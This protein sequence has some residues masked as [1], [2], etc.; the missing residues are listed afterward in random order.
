MRL[1]AVDLPERELARF[2]R[3]NGSWP[4]QEALGAAH[5]EAE[6]IEL[7]PLSDLEGVGLA[8][9]LVEGLGVPEAQIAR[10]R[11]RLEALEGNVMVITSRAFG[12][13]AQELRPRAPLHPIATFTEETPEFHFAPLPSEAARGTAAGPQSAPAAPRQY[14]WPAAALALAILLVVAAIVIAVLA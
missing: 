2:G 9:Y 3:R 4:L 12:G 14:R 6:H 8:G 7:F 10:M 13:V 1:F 11:P 5:L